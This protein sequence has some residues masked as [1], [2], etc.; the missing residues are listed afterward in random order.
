MVP[1]KE[2]TLQKIWNIS[3]PNSKLLDSYSITIYCNI[4]LWIVLLL[5][6]YYMR[7]VY[8]KRLRILGYYKHHSLVKCL[9]L[10]PSF[11]WHKTNAVL[12]LLTTIICSYDQKDMKFGPKIDLKPI[13]LAQI[14]ISLAVLVV[15]PFLIKHF[16]REIRFRIDRNPP[17]IFCVEDPQHL[18][19]SAGLNEIGVR[20]VDF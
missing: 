17:D 12:L 18:V 3:D 20:Y 16:Y 11:V 15:I 19:T 1:L 9:S 4:I 5:I 13:N 6:R 8:Y 10:M 14:V 2:K 7:N